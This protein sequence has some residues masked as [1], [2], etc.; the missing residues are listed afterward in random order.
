[1]GGRNAQGFEAF[2]SLPAP[3]QQRRRL[4]TPGNEVVEIPV[5]SVMI[6][7]GNSGHG[8]S[9]QALARRAR[10]GSVLYRA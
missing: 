10:P 6:N 4:A 1:M 2:Q 7:E 5:A 9:P 8:V 3:F